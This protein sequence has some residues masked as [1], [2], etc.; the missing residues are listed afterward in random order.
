[1][2]QQAAATTRPFRGLVLD[3][4]FCVMPRIRSKA[5]PDVIANNFAGYFSGIYAPNND[6][7]AAALYNEYLLRRENYFGYPFPSARLVL[8]TP[9]L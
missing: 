2:S 1:M 4:P 5:D 9:N 7:H 6:Q 8:S 3:I